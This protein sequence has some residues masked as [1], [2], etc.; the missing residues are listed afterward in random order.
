MRI[1]TIKRLLILFLSVGF[2]VNESFS[3]NTEE[4]QLYSPDRKLN[5]KVSAKNQEITL[6]DEG[7]KVVGIKF[8]INDFQLTS[9]KAK[10]DEEVEIDIIKA[11]SGNKLESIYSQLVITDKQGYGLELRLFDQALAYRQLVPRTVRS[12]KQETATFDFYKDTEVIAQRLSTTKN[13]ET[14]YEQIYE[15]IQ[16]DTLNDLLQLPMVVN[17]QKCK[18]AI[19]EAQLTDYPS[20]YLKKAD[21]KNLEAIF[22][23]YPK[24][25]TIVDKK[26]YTRKVTSRF[27]YIAEWDKKNESTPWRVVQ[28]ARQDIDLLNS[29]F[30][31][32]LSEEQ[33]Q[34]QMTWIRPGKVVWDWYNA[35]RLFNVD[36]EAGINTETYKYYIDFAAKHGI[37]Y[38]NIDEGWSDNGDLFQ[39]KKEVDVPFLAKYANEKGVGIW[40]W[41]VSTTLDKQLEEAL[42]I[43]QEWGISGIKV[44]FFLRDDQQQINLFE[45]FARAAAEHQL[46]LSFHG[47]TRPAG[48]SNEY[49]NVMSYEA[50]RGLEYNKFEG[51][52]G[53]TPDQLVVLPF[54][55]S[56]VGPMDYTPGAML[57]YN[58]EDWKPNFF[59]PS[60][61]GTRC[62]QLAAYIILDSPLQMLAESISYYLQDTTT[63]NYLSNVPVVWDEIIPLKGLLGDYAVTAKRKGDKWYIGGVNNW[64]AKE[65]AIDLSVLGDLGKNIQIFS[66]GINAHYMGQDYNYSITKVPENK[67]L[68]IKMASGGGFV[69]IISN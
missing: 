37:E 9:A 67:Q 7:L 8:G 55:R 13:F 36:F 21:D 35:N 47:T 19:Y 56:L 32:L 11:Y 33:N 50:V 52:T 61:L 26:F 28:L 18:L 14:N 24:S 12:I 31:T 44:D 42:D 48:L 23:K 10:I 25:D 27:D 15:Q 66:D 57:H 38:I 65:L 20:M 53:A 68:K 62:Q 46:M 69:M 4:F 6:F 45:R 16:I 54:I 60:A 64:G 59:R 43:F 39:L 51:S 1:S 17:S 5:V 2:V 29:N 49:P 30:V 34:N 63:L 58:Q 40:L 3:Q 22:P 41:A